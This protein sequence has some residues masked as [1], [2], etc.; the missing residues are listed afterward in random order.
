MISSVQHRRRRLEFEGC[1]TSCFRP[2]ILSAVVC[3]KGD[4]S[5]DQSSE[6]T[7]AQG[8]SI[9]L[10]NV[11]LNQSSPS[12]A[13]AIPGLPAPAGSTAAGSSTV[14]FDTDADLPAAI[15]ALDQALQISQQTTQQAIAT[16]SGWSSGLQKIAAMA[17]ILAGLYLVWKIL[18][19]GK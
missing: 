11:R 14:N 15:A 2:S 17:S 13:P 12:A 18:F 3:Y 7:G 9:L 19:K 6:Q 16:Q 8:G 1:E 4:A 5:L 10:E